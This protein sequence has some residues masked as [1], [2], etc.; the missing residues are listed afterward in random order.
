MQ[1]K[2]HMLLA[3]SRG[4][5]KR[6][7]FSGHLCNDSWLQRGP[8][9]LP[10]AHCFI[11]LYGITVRVT[12]HTGSLV[13]LPGRQNAVGNM[14]KILVT[15]CFCVT[16]TG[17]S[18]HYDESQRALLSTVALACKA[19][20]QSRHTVTSPADDPSPNTSTLSH[21]RFSTLQYAPAG[22]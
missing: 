1:E 2:M 7:A 10:G 9:R 5:W 15:H 6:G 20:A 8:A 4:R 12:G 22:N 16:I 11:M 18:R 17:L 3:A 14:C 13:Q 19:R 21:P